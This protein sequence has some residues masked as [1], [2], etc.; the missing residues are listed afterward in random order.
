METFS[1]IP[2]HITHIMLHEVNRIFSSW[3]NDTSNGSDDRGW[4]Q[5]T[6]NFAPLQHLHRT[7]RGIGEIQRSVEQSDAHAIFPM[8]Q[9]ETSPLSR[10]YAIRP[11]L[12]FRIVYCQ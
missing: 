4:R 5:A 12:G 9:Q 7:D 11:D 10:D 6:A 8:L 1:P 3:K 2:T